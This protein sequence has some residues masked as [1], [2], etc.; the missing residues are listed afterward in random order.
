MSRRK[1]FQNSLYNKVLPFQVIL[2]KARSSSVLV[3]AK[4]FV[5]KLAYLANLPEAK[6]HDVPFRELICRI[7]DVNIRLA[8]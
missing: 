8:Y 2:Q 4:T 7:S 1:L 5:I 6:Q 3:L